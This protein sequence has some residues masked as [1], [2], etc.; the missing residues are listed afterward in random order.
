MCPY[1]HS[2]IIHNSQHMETIY[3]SM[4][5]GMDKDVVP[6]YNGIRLNRKQNCATSS[7]VDDLVN[8]IQSEVS[9][10]ENDKSTRYQLCAESKT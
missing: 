5:K 1:V 7:N 10:K 6:R 3:I 9:Q 4:D 8:I 2:S